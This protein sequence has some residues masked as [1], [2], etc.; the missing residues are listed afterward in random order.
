MAGIFTSFSNIGIVV[1]AL[2]PY[3]I[4][5]FLVLASIFNQKLNG[6]VYLGG[7]VTTAFLC[8]L[9]SLTGI[10]GKN[11]RLPGAALTCDFFNIL[12]NQ[13][14]GPSAMVATSWFTFVYLLIPMLPPIQPNGLINPMVVGLTCFFAIVTSIFQLRNNC[15]SM[16]GIL[17]GAF[18]GLIMGVSW[19][20]LWWISN[21]HDLLFYNEIVSNNAV[22][23]RPKKQSFKCEVWKGGELISQTNI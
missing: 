21:H 2:Y 7:I 22:C 17:L 13:Q 11:G 10:A 14:L 20:F 16:A 6:L 5:S 9:I 23:S 4:V 12:G 19:F 15:N 3:F 18:I 8:Y 1:G